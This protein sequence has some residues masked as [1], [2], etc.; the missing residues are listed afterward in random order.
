MSNFAGE[1]IFYLHF[2]NKLDIVPRMVH[3]IPFFF[4]ILFSSFGMIFL[5]SVHA[6]TSF[7]LIR[8]GIEKCNKLSHWQVAKEYDKYSFSDSRIQS[9]GALTS[10]VIDLNFANLNNFLMNQR[11]QRVADGYGSIC[12]RIFLSMKKLEANTSVYKGSFILGHEGIFYE[13]MEKPLVGYYSGDTAEDNQFNTWHGNWE[14]PDVNFAAIFESSGTVETKF[15][16]V[17]GEK[18]KAPISAVILRINRVEK[19]TSTDG[20]PTYKGHGEVWFK[21][22]RLFWNREDVCYTKGPYIANAHIMPPPPRKKCWFLDMGPY[23]CLPRGIRTM[24]SFDLRGDL[25]CYKKLG[26]FKDLDIRKAFNLSPEEE[27]P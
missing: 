6:E 17:N 21:M 16:S 3:K 22:F 1:G 7:Q 8:E 4:L 15:I 24:E 12:P 9:L 10:A 11:L 2:L 20:E 25:P 26:E 27:H 5:D 23:S 18:E 14:A 13:G 19:S